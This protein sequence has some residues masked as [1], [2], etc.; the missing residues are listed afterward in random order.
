MKITSSFNNRVILSLQS[1]PWD[2]IGWFSKNEDTEFTGEI[3]LRFQ[4]FPKTIHGKMKITWSFLILLYLRF[5]P[6]LNDQ[7]LGLLHE[8]HG[9]FLNAP[10][11]MGV[12]GVT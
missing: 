6:L 2:S 4:K 7:Q 8:R 3:I 12:T 11:F 9:A 5:P 1:L 10:N